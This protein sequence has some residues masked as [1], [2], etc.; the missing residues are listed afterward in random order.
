MSDWLIPAKEEL[1][2]VKEFVDQLRSALA[3][4][5]AA[6]KV[7]LSRWGNFSH[8]WNRRRQ[9]YLKE[10]L[11]GCPHQHRRAHRK[12]HH[13]CER[14]F[15]AWQ[16]IHYT[17]TWNKPVNEERLVEIERELSEVEAYLGEDNG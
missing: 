15:T 17:L 13:A 2:Q 1:A 8:E 11:D 4:E 7:S 5:E 9:A 14:L 10:T 12:V 3:T 16:D 6:E